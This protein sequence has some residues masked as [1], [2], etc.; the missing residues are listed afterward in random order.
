MACEFVPTS[1]YKDPRYGTFVLRVIPV[2]IAKSRLKT[3]SVIHN[4]EFERREL[5]LGIIHLKRDA[6]RNSGIECGRA[7]CLHG[8][9][10]GNRISIRP[11]PGS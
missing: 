3:Q 1:T 11:L 7:G 4:P 6:C 9:Y 5:R 8:N 2:D 10:H